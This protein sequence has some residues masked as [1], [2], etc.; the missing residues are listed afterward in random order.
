MLRRRCHQYPVGGIVELDLGEEAAKVTDIRGRKE[1]EG[2]NGHVQVLAP[3]S[4]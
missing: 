1:R 3:T 2:W 4:T